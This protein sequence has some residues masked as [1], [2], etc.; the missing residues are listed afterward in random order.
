MIN[1]VLNI[2]RAQIIFGTKLHNHKY[3]KL[4]D[5][6]ISNL[7]N[8]PLKEYLILGGEGTWV[9]QLLRRPTLDFSSGHDLTVVRSSPALGSVLGTEPA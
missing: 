2:T 9:A 8:Y 6:N 5:K 7:T 4:S 3:S 1:E